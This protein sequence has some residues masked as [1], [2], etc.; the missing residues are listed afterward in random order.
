MNNHNGNDHNGRHKEARPSSLEGEVLRA[1]PIIMCKECEIVNSKFLP[2]NH[3]TTPAIIMQDET[4]TACFLL[5]IRIT[6][7][8]GSQHYK[9]PE[10]LFLVWQESLY[11]IH[12]IRPWNNIVVVEMC[13]KVWLTVLSFIFIQ[14][15]LFISG[16][17]H[18]S[19]QPEVDLCHAE[20]R[21]HLSKVWRR[22]WHDCDSTNE[23]DICLYWTWEQM[24]LQEMQDHYRLNR[25]RRSPHEALQEE[26]AAA[27]AA[28]EGSTKDTSDWD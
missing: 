16:L 7:G 28:K 3:S 6:I 2:S 11:L 26:L 20:S 21:M 18:I 1:G 14:R 27:E 19:M 15:K 9:W 24:A 10:V 17:H 13:I 25:A 8:T 23:Y 4:L 12:L 22:P 5:L